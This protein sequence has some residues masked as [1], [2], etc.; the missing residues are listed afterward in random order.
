MVSRRLRL[1]VLLP[2]ALVV[3]AGVAIQPFQGVH[4]ASASPLEKIDK[5]LRGHISGT[6]QLEAQGASPQAQARTRG[7]NYYPVNDDGCQVSIGNNVKVNQNC[8]NIADSDLQGR[9][10]AQNETS[11]AIDPNDP[12]HLVASY[13]DYRRGDGT[14]GTSYSLD[15]GR[16][17]IDS[18]TPNSFS[19]GAPFGGAARQYWHASGDTS[20]AWD[21]RGNAYLSC[22]LFNRGGPPTTNNPDLSSAFLVF[23]STANNG[24]SWNFPGRYVAAANDLAGTGALF[25]DKQLMTVDN[26]VS[27]PF[28]DRIYVTWTEFTATTA[29]IY[30]AYSND[31]GEHFSNKVLVSSSSSLC[32]FP[33]SKNGGCDNNQFS[34]PFTAPDGT[35][36]VVW[37]NFNTVDLGAKTLA[38]ARFQVLMA[39][40]KD[41]GA[42]YSAPKRVASYYELPDCPTYQNGLDPTRACVPEKGPTTNSIF[43]ATNYP[44]GGVN[45]ANPNQVV[46]SIGSYI[47][48]TSKEENGCVPTGTDPVGTG[49]YTG[50]KTLGACHNAILTSVSTDAGATFTG[51]NTDPR[52]L[53]TA[54]QDPGQKTTDQWF[55][56]LDFFRDGRVAISYYDRQYGSDEITGYSDF[57]L[58]T[59]R[60]LTGYDVRRVTSGSMPPPTQFGGV[61]WGDY[62][63]LAAFDRAFPIWSDTRPKD[64]FLC[65]GTGAVGVPPRLCGAQTGGLAA[66]DQD[67][68]TAAAG[69]RGGLGGDA[70]QD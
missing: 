25:E 29:Y 19:R 5:R 54:T 37:S 40:S 6:L 22:Q 15:G 59:S 11:I 65:P 1:L 46:V 56:W 42:T 45:P 64:L 58:S 30:G 39:T 50:V 2:A 38:P 41:G 27:S 24:G 36:Y 60:N 23:R 68:F 12:R 61:F 34:Q 66:N 53:T 16:N 7:S 10:Q 9:S 47:N 20:V 63:G 70:S 55:Q 18:T 52:Q 62:T 14:C 48:Q 44:S 67:I 49:L 31:Y 17:W 4:Q 8:L 21:T 26:H 33:I 28:R 69:A 43:R 13:N 32:R 3:A 57:S 51:T 35:L